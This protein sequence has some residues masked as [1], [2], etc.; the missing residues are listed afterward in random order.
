MVPTSRAESLSTTFPLLGVA[1]SEQCTSVWNYT[2]RINTFCIEP[3]TF[4]EIYGVLFIV[5]LDKMVMFH[6]MFPW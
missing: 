2:C 3:R 5:Y 1:S 4:V 6:S